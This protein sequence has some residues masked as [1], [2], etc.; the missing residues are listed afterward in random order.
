MKAGCRRQAGAWT[1]PF[2]T[3]GRQAGQGDTPKTLLSR[4]GATTQRILSPQS[5]PRLPAFGGDT[6]ESDSLSHARPPSTQRKAQSHWPRM[7]R[8]LTRMKPFSRGT[9]ANEEKT[10]SRS[11]ATARRCRKPSRHEGREVHP[12]S[13]GHEGHEERQNEGAGRYD[14]TKKRRRTKGVSRIGLPAVAG[15]ENAQSGAG[16]YNNL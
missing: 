4:N 10:C 9:E 7:N 1:K 12:P 6:K 16:R 2:S 14:T 3:P 5:S 13:A 11:G 15:A 8:G